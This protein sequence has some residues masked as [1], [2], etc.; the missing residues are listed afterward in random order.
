MGVIALVGMGLRFLWPVGPPNIIL[1]SIDTLRAD[2]LGCY[3]QSR[4]LTPNIDAF[5]QQAVRF[6]SATSPVPLTLPAH[7]SMMTG[8]LPPCH[9]IHNNIH[10]RVPDGS[11]TLAERLQQYGYETAAMIGAYVLDEKFGLAQGFDTYDDT[12]DESLK[13]MT[14]Y[15]ERRAGDVNRS[16]FNWLDHRASKPFFLFAHYYDP[17]YPYRP[18]APYDSLHATSL[19]AG[20]VAYTDHQVGTLLSKLKEMKLFDSSLIVITADHGEGLGEHGENYH[21]FF[22]YRSTTH[23]PLLIKL[24]H[25]QKGRVIRDQAS[26][27]DLVPTLLALAGF[28]TPAELPGRDWSAFLSSDTPSSSDRLVF[29]ESMLGTQFGINSLLGLESRRWK[30]IQTTR[31]ELYDLIS[32]PGE[33]INLATQKPD[34][35]KGF[36]EELSAILE[37]NRCEQDADSHQTLDPESIAKLRALGYTGGPLRVTFDFEADLPD[38]KDFMHVLDKIE[39]LD[40]TINQGKLDETKE[41]YQALLEGGVELAFVYAKAGQVAVLEQRDRDALEYFLRA[42]E[43][44]KDNPNWHNNIGI[45]HYRLGDLDKAIQAL[46]HTIKLDPDH[47][48]QALLD[49]LLP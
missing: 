8:V 16:V 23:V 44:E 5:A 29:T 24:P 39:S 2:H 47:K 19:Y 33:L 32:D 18:P 27:I 15:A 43:L 36:Q 10:Y 7:T 14:G 12:M 49:Q 11:V 20:E 31:P 1:I 46:Q 38:P 26:L 40:Y 9:G 28:D 4:N 22:V 30:F 45:L 3:G 37:A 34:H 17:H 35:V 41:V 21:G 42:V 48:A 25:Q 6:T 13:I